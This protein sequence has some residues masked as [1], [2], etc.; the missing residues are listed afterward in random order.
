MLARSARGLPGRKRGCTLYHGHPWPGGTNEGGGIK[1]EGGGICRILFAIKTHDDDDVY[2]MMI[3][4]LM[5]E[6]ESLDES[7]QDARLCGWPGGREGASGHLL[8]SLRSSV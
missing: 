7:E 4:L 1:V 5:M 6:D 8:P 3:D 2:M